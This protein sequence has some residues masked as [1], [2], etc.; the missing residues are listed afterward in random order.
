MSQTGKLLMFCTS[1]PTLD[2]PEGKM[3]Q[4][5]FHKQIPLR[6]LTPHRPPPP[7]LRRDSRFHTESPPCA[8]DQFQC[9]NGRCIGQ[10]KVC[11][12][13][14]DCGDGTDEQPHHD[15]REWTPPSSLNLPPSLPT[16]WT[17]SEPA[18]PEN[19]DESQGSGPDE[20]GAL[21]VCFTPAQPVCV[22][23]GGAPARAT[24]TRT[25]EAAPRSVRWPEA[26]STAPATPDTA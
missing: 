10:R 7:P 19:P 21:G 4:I 3:L 1:S 16:G 24:A 12:E 22:Q 6:C 23:Q 9:G 11:N 2:Q 18:D 26:W 17:G 14:N 20:G 8:P 15:C 5:S 13:V 25:T